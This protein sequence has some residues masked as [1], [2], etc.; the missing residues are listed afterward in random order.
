M[1]ARRP[2]VVELLQALIRNACVN[3]GTPDSG[4]EHRSVATLQAY[5]GRPGT[6]IEPHP[7]RQSVVYRVE[8]RD[9]DAP[10]LALLPH[11]DVVPAN[12]KG[13]SRDPFAAE[14][15][16]GFVWGRG[17]LDMLNITAAMAAVFRP[18]L[19]GELPPLPGDL[20]LGAVADEEAGGALGAGY[21]VEHHWDLIA[22]DDLLTEVA[23]PGFGAGADAVLPVTVA[24]KGPSWRTLRATGEPGHASQ[25]HGTRNALVP[26][27]VAAARLAEEPLPV[28]I[29][30]EWRRFVTAVGLPAEL[31]DP[32]SVDDAVAGLD[33][34][35]P[36]L[37]RWAHACTHLTVT[38]TV[39][40]AGT[41]QNVVPDEGLLRIDARL[42]PG[43]D[44]TAV[45]D[46]LGEVLGSMLDDLAVT[47]DTRFAPTASP[48]SGP[49]W[50]AMGDAAG[51]GTGSRRLAP[52]LIPVT[53]DA[54]FF[55][56]RGVHAYGA[57]LFD[58]RMGFGELLGMFHGNDERVSEESV[59][60]TTEFLA[61]TVRRFGERTSR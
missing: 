11:L 25:P 2:D 50:E 4:Q 28:L 46:H 32:A 55:R 13:W 35:D 26:L 43:Q 40:E 9:P 34:V 6:V 12:P 23:A 59:G 56:A 1:T 3:D 33:A 58:D 19:T 10:A 54:R 45:D 52:M 30:D 48:T 57:G 27:A 60:R 49:L 8:G 39:I 38:P 41:A 42:L 18:Y 14:R 16:E 24:E 7:G 37:G 15:H 47:T 5:L 61:T 22:C 53:T 29:T 44:D 20:V 21:L 51:A 31:T 36:A 17:A